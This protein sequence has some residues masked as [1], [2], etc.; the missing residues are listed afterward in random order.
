MTEKQDIP[1]S[2]KRELEDLVLIV[3]LRREDHAKAE[4]ILNQRTPSN[5]RKKVLRAVLD[6]LREHLKREAI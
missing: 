2:Y 5:E 4:L 1:L 6:D 3:L